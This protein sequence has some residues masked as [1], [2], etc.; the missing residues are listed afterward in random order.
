MRR[1][2]QN[3]VYT[4]EATETYDENNPA[5][6]PVSWG[7]DAEIESQNQAMTATTGD[8][9][10]LGALITFTPDLPDLFNGAYVKI[11]PVYAGNETPAIELWTHNSVS[12]AWEK[13]RRVSISNLLVGVRSTEAK[14]FRLILDSGGLDN[15]DQVWITMAPSSPL[16]SQANAFLAIWMYGTCNERVFTPDCPPDVPPEDCV[17]NNDTEDDTNET[18]PC[19]CAQIA[20]TLGVN[21]ADLCAEGFDLAAFLDTLGIP[22][23]E[24]CG[25]PGTG[26][27]DCETFARSLGL[28]PNIVCRDL[29]CSEVAAALGLDPNDICTGP[30]GPTG[31][32]DCEAAAR[33]LGLDP[34]ATCRRDPPFPNE[35]FPTD[36]CDQEGVYVDPETLEPAPDPQCNAPAVIDSPDWHKVYENLFFYA[37][38]QSNVA[39]VRAQQ[40]TKSQFL[41]LRLLPPELQF[42]QNLQDITNYLQSDAFNP[43]ANFNTRAMTFFFHGLQEGMVLTVT[44]NTFPVED[45]IAR[46]VPRYLR[47]L[48]RGEFPPENLAAF[49]SVPLCSGGGT[50]PQLVFGRDFS[51]VPQID[52]YTGDPIEPGTYHILRG[53][54]EGPQYDFLE[55]RPLRRGLAP[56]NPLAAVDSFPTCSPVPYVPPCCQVL[57]PGF[58]F[59]IRFALYLP[60]SNGAPMID[61]TDFSITR[62]KDFF[63]STITVDTT[64]FSVCWP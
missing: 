48:K 23:D 41:R 22:L 54:S 35:Q 59:M 63:H 24:I 7:T 13:N 42:Y 32:F 10:H 33:F 55:I 31:P 52:K 12:G 61:A 50:Q 64:S 56:S 6:G 46:T 5:T 29:T 34:E 1:I 27:S 11:R 20:R 2:R 25:P 16:G 47:Q 21:P 60:I 62:T 58:A 49:Q 51:V 3:S 39:R 57:A 17:E 8:K 9:S 15:I 43:C 40:L 30:L 4:L 37:D 19:D 14:V 44:V 45:F 53:A 28:D 36:P 26:I 18:L 38:S